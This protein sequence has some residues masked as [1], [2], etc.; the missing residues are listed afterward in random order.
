MTDT[1]KQIEIAVEIDATNVSNV[2]VEYFVSN[3][4]NKPNVADI[5]CRFQNPNCGKEYEIRQRELRDII[6]RHPEYVEQCVKE[7]IH[8]FLGESK[9]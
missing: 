3:V 6:D 8:Q 1:V 9:V 5:F 2:I 4:K 7:T